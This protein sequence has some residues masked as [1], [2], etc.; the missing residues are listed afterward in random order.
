ME[1]KITFLRFIHFM[2]NEH[3]SWLY[4]LRT[5][6]KKVEKR[7]EISKRFYVLIFM[8][9]QMHFILSFKVIN[10]VLICIFSTLSELL[11]INRR[12]AAT[13]LYKLPALIPAIRPVTNADVML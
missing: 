8:L 11:K 10:I 2:Q 12:Y 13:F 5:K 9:I 7:L 3:K 4:K 1:S 6:T